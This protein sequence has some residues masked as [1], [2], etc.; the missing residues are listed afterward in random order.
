MVPLLGYASKSLTTRKITTILTAGGMAL[1]TFVF[2]AVLMLAEGL[3]YTLTETGAKENAI[4]L[5]GSAETEVQ[6]AISRDEASIIELQPEVPVHSDGTPMASKETLVLVALSKRGSRKPS[7]VAVR[8]AGP[9]A[10]KLRPQVK[11][12]AG[13]MFRPGA[14]EIVVGSSIAERVENCALGEIP[15]LRADRVESG[16]DIRRGR[17][18]VQLRDL[19]GGGP[20]DG[21]LQKVILLGGHSSYSRQVGLRVL[22]EAS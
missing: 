9:H 19:G 7:H 1:V 8:G 13:R 22:Q 11:L 5:R 10:M 16:W 3:E 17:H 15:E 2:V 4:V 12:V 14:N 21:G 18:R 6:S 20:F